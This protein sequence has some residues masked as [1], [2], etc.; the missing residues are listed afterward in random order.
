[1]AIFP[2]YPPN[3]S[4]PSN[5]ECN[6]GI[7]RYDCNTQNYCHGIDEDPNGEYVKREDAE[8][9]IATLT[10]ERDKLKAMVLECVKRG[11][12]MAVGHGGV[13]LGLDWDG[14]DPLDCDGTPDSILAAVE[15]AMGS[16]SPSAEP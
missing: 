9:A 4:G 7:R 3:F 10:A 12:C 14:F 5:S 15:R 6:A 2:M 11:A 1:M 8:S 13:I 16:S